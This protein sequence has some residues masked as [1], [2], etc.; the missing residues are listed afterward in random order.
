MRVCG[1]KQGEDA[2]GEQEHCA[3]SWD[4]S[5]RTQSKL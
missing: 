4:G 5:R 2:E 1:V 3:K